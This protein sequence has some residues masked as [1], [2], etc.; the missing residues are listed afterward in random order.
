MSR[1]VV[2]SAA[3]LLMSA[4][5][6]NAWGVVEYT[7]TDLGTLGGVS[8]VAYGINNNGTVV[9]DS[10][11]ASNDDRAFCYSNGTMTDLG[12]MGGNLATSQ[13][14]ACGINASGQIAGYT[15][16]QFGDTPPIY[17]FRYT[18][19]TMTNLGVVPGTPYSDTSAYGINDSGQVVGACLMGYS[20]GY[21]IYHAFLYS[22][23]SMA[24]MGAPAAYPSTTAYAINNNEQIVGTIVLNQSEMEIPVRSGCI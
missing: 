19:G 7:P 20:G 18:N 14:F 6:E 3:V 16:V 13:N 11:D 22:N 15:L 2:A 10:R 5:V 21:P 9:G 23:G 8:S 4:I 17:G 12:S 24:D 1:L